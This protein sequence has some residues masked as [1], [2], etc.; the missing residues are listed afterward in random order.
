MFTLGAFVSQTS[1]PVGASYL[2]KGM[3][4][5]C[6]DAVSA[7]LSVPLC[8]STH[9]GAS[10]PATPSVAREKSPEPLEP[11]GAML[12]DSSMSDSESS[13]F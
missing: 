8:I 1:T 12:Q 11:P 10:Q 9:G 13:D 3:R 7:K 2:N 6:H 5:D 4:R